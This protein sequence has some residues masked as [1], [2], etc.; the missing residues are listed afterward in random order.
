MNRLTY[1]FPALA[2]LVLGCLLSLNACREN[3][4]INT[5]VNPTGDN[6]FT[7]NAGDTLTILTRV[8]YEDSVITSKSNTGY[9]ILH[10]LG[11]ATDP[12]AGKTNAAIYFQVL[13]PATS[14]SLGEGGTID[15]AVLVL[16]YSGTTWGDSTATAPLQNFRVYQIGEA[17]SKDSSYYSF[18][19]KSVDYSRFYGN[20]MV[21]VAAL[22]DSVK[23]WDT[24]RTPH[25]RI[26]LNSTFIAD[27]QNALP[28]DSSIA[29]FLNAFK[30][31][32]LEADSTTGGTSIPYFRIDGQARPY[33]R[34]SVIL[35]YHNNSKDSLT[36]S[37]AF[38]A[39]GAAH[40]NAI[41]R[42][43]NGTPAKTIMDAGW[44][45]Q[46]LLVMQNSPGAVIEVKI[47]YLANLPKDIIIN[48]A[49]LVITAIDTL[50]SNTFYKPQRLVPAGVDSNGN[51]FNIADVMGV[52][53]SNDGY[54]FI[55]GTRREAT[56]GG[57]S[58]SQ[59]VMNIPAE[60]QKVISGARPELYLRIRGTA[61]LPAAYRLIA[62]GP[63]YGGATRIQLNII[64]SKQ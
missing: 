35:Y 6:I 17:L 63:G 41:T 54:R 1:K 3:T 7:E 5:G 14:F 9:F 15:S 44:G 40:Y 13:P 57:I 60:V 64:Y 25:L 42:N 18:Q 31:F 45:A 30:G 2:L 24:M 27:I 22:K 49:E 8:I 59:Y 58:V 61:T 28:A 23:I 12:F 51:L 50:S 46:P 55:D 47:P 21:Q 34:A 39:S 56:V 33:D 11:Q 20:K 26:P 62:A 32:Y 16:P 19:K 37:F 36:A 29:S 38:D 52:S 10:G 53:P 4:I 48:K 43:Y